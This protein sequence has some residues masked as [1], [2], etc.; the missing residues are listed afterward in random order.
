MFTGFTAMLIYVSADGKTCARFA[1]H[2]QAHVS[3]TK[4]GEDADEGN[5][6]TVTGTDIKAAF[7]AIN[8]QSEGPFYFADGNAAWQEVGDGT[9]DVSTTPLI[10]L[11]GVLTYDFLPLCSYVCL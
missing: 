10:F 3:M 4:G 8:V 9:L 2:L 11:A 5:A 1:M 7:A 6:L